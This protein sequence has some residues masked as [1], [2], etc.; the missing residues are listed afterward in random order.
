MER[1][2]LGIMSIVEDDGMGFDLNILGVK[3]GKRHLG[4]ISMKERAEILGVT[5]DVYTAPGK[6]TT[7]QG[8]PAELIEMADLVTE[9]QPIRHPFDQGINAQPG[10]EF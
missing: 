5:L 10:I 4:L 9:M 2:P 3:R 8:A 6:G 1:N 7:I